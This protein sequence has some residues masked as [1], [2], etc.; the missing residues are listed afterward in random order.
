MVANEFQENCYVLRE[1]Y[2]LCA[3][4]KGKF[5]YKKEN[6]MSLTPEKKKELIKQFGNDENDTGSPESQ[7]AIFTERI[8]HLSDHLKANKKD[9]STQRS[10]FKLVGRRRKLLDYL[11]KKDIYRYRNLIAALGIR[12]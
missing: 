12:K 3:L 8:K 4:L 6:N 11:K 9:F 7:V 2:Y 1:S 10:L 5:K